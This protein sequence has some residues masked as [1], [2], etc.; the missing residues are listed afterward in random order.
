[1]LSSVFW[2]CPGS[3][4]QYLLPALILNKVSAGFDNWTPNT[5]A[6]KLPQVLLRSIDPGHSQKTEDNI[7]YT[8]YRRS[9]ILR[10]R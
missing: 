1:M 3:T 4:N 8:P 10:Q 6:K 7:S 9:T 2:L 5:V